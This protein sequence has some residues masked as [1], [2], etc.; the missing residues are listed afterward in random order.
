LESHNRT[1]NALAITLAVGFC[2]LLLWVEFNLRR[3][4]RLASI[5]VPV[6]GR[7]IEKSRDKERNRTICRIRY[8]FNAPDGMRSGELRVG[9]FLWGH[10][11]HGTPITVLYDPDHPNRHCPS[12]GFR[13][14]QFLP[15]TAEE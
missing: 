12:F 11:C 6:E 2:L 4:L 1:A 5:G 8:L 9:E 7:I 13:L 15:E 14:V 3:E 10:L